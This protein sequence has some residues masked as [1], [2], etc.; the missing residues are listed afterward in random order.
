[1]SPELLNITLDG[2]NL[3]WILKLSKQI[4]TGEFKWCN[5][6]RKR[7]PKVKEK[8]RS[9]TINPPRDKIV[10]KAIYLVLNEIFE[11][12]LNH[13]SERSHGFRPGKSCHSALAEIKFGW[14][15]VNWYVEYGIKKAFNTVNK[16]R[17]MLLLKEKIQDEGLMALLYKMFKA[18]TWDQNQIISGARNLEIPQGNIL[19]PIFLNIYMTELDR[20]VENLTEE[21]NTGERRRKNPEYIKAI[22][23][24]IEV[25]KEMNKFQIEQESGKLRRSAKSIPETINDLGMIKV[26]YIRF[27]D[28]FIV[29]ILGSKKIARKIQK[30][31]SAKIK[32][33]LHLEIKEEKTKLTNIYNDKAHF[34]GTII[35][36][37]KEKHLTSFKPQAIEKR[38]R[39]MNR[40]NLRKT[41]IEKKINKKSAMEIWKNM[42]ENPDRL[43]DVTNNIKKPEFIQIIQNNRRAG[44]RKLAIK[45]VEM[46]NELQLL[47]SES[48]EIKKAI[49]TLKKVAQNENVIEKQ[50]KNK[51]KLMTKPLTKTYIIQ[52]IVEIYGDEIFLGTENTK[53]KIE[54]LRKVGHKEWPKSIKENKILSQ[55]QIKKIKQIGK[56]EV[57]LR[58]AAILKILSTKDIETKSQK[59]AMYEYEEIEKK[60]MQTIR[61]NK[62]PIIS[63]N[64]DTL[65][66]KLKE[67][68]I[69]KQDK[70]KKK[71][72]SRYKSLLCEDYE[73][74]EYYRSFALKILNYYQCCDNFHS[75]KSIVNYFIRQSLAL[76]LKH[77]HKASSSHAIY[78]KYGIN[79]AVEN[80]KKKGN[81]ISFLTRHEVNAKKKKFQKNSQITSPF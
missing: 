80:P 45:L 2:I 73:I 52:K 14:H 21:M 71:S 78:N 6:K 24:P 36:S 22:T 50:I 34:L 1:M 54:V 27:A 12:K 61:F 29:G 79:I 28:D 4:K 26:K 30:L 48:I 17:L 3:K 75:I 39:V 37:R 40:I 57:G 53:S 59:I 25:K 10:Q 19:S 32:N 44:L 16:N 9:L 62:G 5:R 11:V 7:I 35:Y 58:L 8:T 81:H 31:V 64:L 67:N 69:I 20:Y 76:T 56:K 43:T 68:D 15:S 47:D 63:A 13:F 18:K 72:K 60:P 77:K 66:E 41:T 55:E 70:N 23:I 49:E 51:T 33:S 74:I 65:Y 46:E 38:R 42:M